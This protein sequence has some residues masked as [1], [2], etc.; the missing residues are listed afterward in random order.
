MRSSF[1][2]MFHQVSDAAWFEDLLLFL[3]SNYQFVDADQIYQSLLEKKFREAYCHLSFDDGHGSFYK[4]A[5]PILKKHR[6][7]ASLF[8]SPKMIVSSQNYWFQNLKMLPRDD[9]HVFLQHRLK[10]QFKPKTLKAVSNVAILK[11][12]KYH[13]ISSLL[14]EF[15]EE[16]GISLSPGFNI[17]A[18][19][20]EEIIDTGLVEVGAHT[21]YHPILANENY[22]IVEIEITQSIMNTQ[23]LTQKPVRF[24][25]CPNGGYGRDFGEREIMIMKRNG[26]IMNFSTQ[27][28]H[29]RFKYGA[30]RVP[31]IGISKGSHSFINLKILHPR[32]W[33][34][35]R[36]ISN[37]NSEM[38]QRK[39]LVAARLLS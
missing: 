12:L 22:D 14:S 31:R 34:Y 20:L 29:L 33:S 21:L 8:I 2:A 11:S 6:I 39:K 18:N 37:P 4:T 32:L 28:D 17:D 26:V 15:C 10:G 13:E 9:F 16:Y 23:E 36:D 19:Q 35:I 3:G 38:N 7:P 24:F 30:Y 27:S 25:A 1:V 5:L